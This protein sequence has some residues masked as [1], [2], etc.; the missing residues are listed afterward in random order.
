MTVTTTTMDGLAAQRAALT[1]WL[2]ELP[3]DSWDESV[4]TVLD[5]LCRRYV[6]AAESD[7]V[8]S[9]PDDPRGA[10]EVV[11]RI[12]Q[13][14]ELTFADKR[15]PGNRDG[16]IDLVMHGVV[17]SA[18]RLGALTGRPVPTP[19]RS[20]DAAVA[21]VVW[22]AADKVEAPVRIIL[23]T[24]GDYVVGAGEPQSV[25]HTD[26]EA[27]LAVAGGRAD[28]AELARSGRWRFE[29]PDEARHAFE[30]TFRA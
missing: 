23:E 3:T 12:G 15:A 14:V 6:A 10:A 7:V 1:A 13:G 5:A 17:E 24:G 22:R 25:L 20:R 30:R 18:R 29:G 19:R 27:V 8:V 9:V 16:G 26:P 11:D 28:P 21:A 4:R 2:R